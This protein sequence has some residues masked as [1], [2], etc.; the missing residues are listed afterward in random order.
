M[1]NYAEG[2]DQKYLDRFK[3]GQTFGAKDRAR[4]DAFVKQIE[5]KGLNKEVAAEAYRGGTFG[6]EDQKRYDALMKARG[7]QDQNTT[8]TNTTT[9]TNTESNSNP[10]TPETPETPGNPANPANPQAPDVVSEVPS[11]QSSGGTAQGGSAASGIKSDTGLGGKAFVDYFK[12]AGQSKGTKD[13]LAE[14][15]ANAQSRINDLD[16]MDT[17]AINTDL[18][19]SI[20]DSYDRSNVEN[21]FTFGDMRNQDYKSPSW[22]NSAP[23]PIKA[24]DFKELSKRYKIKD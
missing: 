24:P 23:E 6:A 1:S 12:D 5:G 19:R 15:R 10:G 21:F 11:P 2:V 4:Y 20:Q 18:N 17:S 7:Y 9:N 13:Y 22:E 3:G 14:Y 8:T 16:V